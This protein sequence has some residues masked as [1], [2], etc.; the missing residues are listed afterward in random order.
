ME[1]ISN[2]LTPLIDFYIKFHLLQSLLLAFE[3]FGRLA[4]TSELSLAKYP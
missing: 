2:V 4:I 3:A 1:K